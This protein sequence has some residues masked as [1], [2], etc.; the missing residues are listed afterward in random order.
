[1]GFTVQWAIVGH[2]LRHRHMLFWCMSGAS[3]IHRRQFTFHPRPNVL[4]LKELYFTLKR[5]VSHQVSDS[6]N[7]EVRVVHGRKE[8]V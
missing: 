6:P 5:P 4:L 1:M 2:R 3:N 7:A 8:S